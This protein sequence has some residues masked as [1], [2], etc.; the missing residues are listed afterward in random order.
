MRNEAIVQNELKNII[1]AL[2]DN[3]RNK[4]A[5]G[6]KKDEEHEEI[7]KNVEDELLKQIKDKCADL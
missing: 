5:D 2:G 1:E 4:E 7:I 3:I 6:K